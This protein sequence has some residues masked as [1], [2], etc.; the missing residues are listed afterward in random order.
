MCLTI[1]DTFHKKGK[2]LVAERSIL[3][4]KMLERYAGKKYNN[5]YHTP[6][7]GTPINFCDEGDN[8]YFYKATRLQKDSIY[9]SKGIHS[10]SDK[11]TA[12]DEV[13]MY[14][15]GSLYRMSMHY[16]VIPKGSKFFIGSDGDI[17]STNLVVFKRKKDYDKNKKLFGR[18]Y[19]LGRYL[20]DF[21]HEDCK[22]K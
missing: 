16:A 7:M 5:Q 1:K 3:V 2:P 19:E 6:Y 4:Y 17:V 8:M 11:K 15:E 12:I 21:W 13:N 22:S 10:F 18:T 9:I 20:M 14:N